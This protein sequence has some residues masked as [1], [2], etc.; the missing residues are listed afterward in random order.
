MP[1]LIMQVK[2]GTAYL[3]KEKYPGRKVIIATKNIKDFQRVTECCN[4]QDINY[5]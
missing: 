1:A 4:W 2:C 5:L 3:I